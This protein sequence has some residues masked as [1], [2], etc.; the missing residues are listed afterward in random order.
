MN[1]II[2]LTTGTI[3]EQIDEARFKLDRWLTVQPPPPHGQVQALR[4][5]SKSGPVLTYELTCRPRIAD[6]ARMI[7]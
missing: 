1:H 3:R 5:V 7:L 4:L 6:E 2:T